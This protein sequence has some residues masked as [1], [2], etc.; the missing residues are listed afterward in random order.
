[1]VAPCFAEVIEKCLESCE[2]FILDFE[3]V[4]YIA[5]AGLRVL[6]NMQQE[7]DDSE[8]FSVKIINISESVR[9]VLESTGFI[10]ILVIE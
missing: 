8:S 3:E 1:M 6:L 10:D 5:S 4:T 2:D 9:E 7:I